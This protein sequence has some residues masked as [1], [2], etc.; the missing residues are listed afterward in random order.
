MEQNIYLDRY[1]MQSTIL[2]GNRNSSNLNQPLIPGNKSNLES[3]LR[4]LLGGDQK[5]EQPGFYWAPDQRKWIPDRIPSLR[6]QLA[7]LEK[8]FEEHTLSELNIGNSK[9]RVWPDHLLEQR[10][11][12]NAKLQVAEEEQRELERLLEQAEEQQKKA[13]P[14][15]LTHPRNWGSGSLRHGVLESIGPWSVSPNEEGLLV[16]DDESSP[17]HTMPVWRFK[18]EILKPMG[19]EFAR[20]HK[21]EEQN[22][23]AE[24]RTRRKVSYP[25]PGIWRKESDL[26]EYESYSNEVIKKLKREN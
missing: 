5:S 16:I 22:A 26:I 9:P 10:D 23:V 8:K 17:Y 15:L 6:E 18:S 2:A 12:L 19:M 1:R 14:S 21:Q 24:T 7:G 11:R 25:E 4:Q 20:R 3:H 13:R